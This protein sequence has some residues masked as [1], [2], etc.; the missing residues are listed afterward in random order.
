MKVVMDS[1]AAKTS[2]RGPARWFARLAPGI[3]VAATGV[4]A[5]D[6]LT[7]TLVGSKLHLTV[8]WAVVIGGLLK[9]TLNEGL[10]RWQM[11]TGTTL[12]E[13]WV[14]H[15]GRWIQWLFLIY[16][17][18]WTVVTG[19]ALMK[20]CGVAAA[21]LMGAGLF[22]DGHRTVIIWGAVHSLVGAL[23][24]WF[25]GYR[26]F[27]RAMSFC[28]ALMFFSVMIT[29]LWIPPDWSLF[30]RGLL[31]P[32]LPVGGGIYLMALLGGVGGT[33]TLLSYGYWIREAQ[34]HGHA[35]VRACRLDL[36]VGY[37]MT[38]L[39]GLA[40]VTIGS[41]IDLS[42]VDKVSPDLALK[43]ADQLAAALGPS[44]RWIF[45][46]GFWGAVFS[47]LLGV[48]QSVP[49]MFADFMALR[50]GIPT[51]QR[52]ALDLSGTWAY[53]GYLLAIAVVPLPLLVLP[54]AF[55]QFTYAALG[56]CFMPLLAVT[57]LLLNNRKALV[58]GPFRNHLV[59]NLILV[60]T[61]V[62]FATLGARAIYDRVSSL[63]G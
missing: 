27:E 34:R 22:G 21:G 52:A 9:W 28:I 41:R 61:T 7:A 42:D 10:A 5:G 33:L 37:T 29:A 55:V 25:G 45:L 17:M 43:L 2:N 35:G 31:I 46:L 32:S 59:V 6:L 63:L 16:L 13:G 24:V 4:G 44:G 15:L 53:R 62:L 48:W 58:G 47:S 3:L 30:T 51:E 12:L 18:F 19:G 23:L 60:A 38:V 50:R 20:A 14:E 11:A 26:V 1:Q 57:L 40:M 39:F 49:Y 54:L 56:A 8:L 36:A